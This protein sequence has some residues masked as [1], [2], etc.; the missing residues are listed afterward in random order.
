MLEIQVKREI[1]Q[2]LFTPIS[3]HKQVFLLGKG[4]GLTKIF[5]VGK[6]LGLYK[7][8]HVPSNLINI[9]NVVLRALRVWLGEDFM[10]HKFDT[11][12]LV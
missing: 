10:G 6:G 2:V 1:C 9:H 8:R 12:S 3:Y 4:F 5:L 11:L 7:Q